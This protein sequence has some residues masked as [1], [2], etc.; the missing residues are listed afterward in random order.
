MKVVGNTSTIRL[1]L[2]FW[3]K[4]IWSSEC[5]QGFGYWVCVYSMGGGYGG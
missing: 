2:C 4:W 5:D 1:I 3:E